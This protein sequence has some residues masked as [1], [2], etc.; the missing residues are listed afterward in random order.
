MRQSARLLRRRKRRS[1]WSLPDATVEPIKAA[2][3]LL[4]GA[5]GEW[6]AKTKTARRHDLQL[7][8]LWLEVPS[9]EHA[10]VKLCSAEGQRLAQTW[11]DSL[12]RVERYETRRRK[13]STL[14]SVASMAYF[15]NFS[16]GSPSL[17]VPKTTLQDMSGPSVETIRKL[18]TACGENPE[19]LRNQ[20]MILLMATLAL[21]RCEPT[22]MLR[23]DYNREK[24]HLFVRG[25]DKHDVW[26]KVPVVAA[27]A[28]EKWL[29][30]NPEKQS[31][32]A[33]FH[34]LG[35]RKP[36]TPQGISFIFAKLSERIGEKVRPGGFRHFGLTAAISDGFSWRT[37]RAFGR[38]RSIGGPIPYDDRGSAPRTE[39]AVATVLYDNNRTDAPDDPILVAEAVAKK[40][41][42]D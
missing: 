2:K 27:E 40:L 30:S 9:I 31:E 22:R 16:H 5:E 38:H 41:T 14:R 24:R 26:V 12:F 23:K 19:G 36:L 34:S 32:E 8:A 35:R 1:E 33:I 6:S 21:R 10:I 3:A 15:Y 11:L 28:L 29:D 37:V 4:R 18:L 25:K 13:S 7:F 20:A 42:D 17:A 39:V